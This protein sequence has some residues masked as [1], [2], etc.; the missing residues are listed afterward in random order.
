MEGLILIVAALM[1]LGALLV[2]GLLVIMYFRMNRNDRYYDE[3]VIYGNL[4]QCPQCGHMNPL[5]TAACLNC[6]YPLPVPHIQQQPTAGYPVVPPPAAPAP[7]PY[8]GP[9]SNVPAP[10][11]VPPAAQPS[12]PAYQAPL[13]APSPPPAAAP[14]SPDV[15]MPSQVAAPVERRVSDPPVRPSDLPAEMPLA[16][17]EGAGGA[18]MGHRAVLTQTDTLIGRSTVCDIQ[19][20]DPKVS[21]QHVLIRFANGSFF[22]QDQDSSRGTFINGERVM[23]QRL[24]DGD[25]I[26]IGDSGMTFHL[27][28]GPAQS[29]DG[30]QS[31]PVL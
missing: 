11:P 8:Y 13:V 24:K 7:P 20:F 9:P 12:P 19:V 30:V 28:I 22:I 10:A 4:I 25:H 23:A 31:A 26:E 17:L 5:G 14:S 2:G 1:G 21:R 16:W 18:M 15:T 3:P 29:S 27:Q 6:R